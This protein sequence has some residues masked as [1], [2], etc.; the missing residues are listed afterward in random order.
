MTK[1]E[2]LSRG[3]A[4][5]KDNDPIENEVSKKAILVSAIVGWIVC[6][7]LFLLKMLITKQVDLG[8]WSLIFASS[9]AEMIYRG[10]KLGIKKTFMVGIVFVILASIVCFG[11]ICLMICGER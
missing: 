8:L 6:G 5:Y 9:G 2:I 3:R 1:E 10:K 11:Y 4:D 7:V